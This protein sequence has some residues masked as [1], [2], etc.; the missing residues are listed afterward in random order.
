MDW[1]WT[2]FL[3]WLIKLLLIICYFTGKG[4]ELCYNDRLSKDI[5]FL[6]KFPTFGWWYTSLWYTWLEWIFELVYTDCLFL[7]KLILGINIVL[8]LF[9]YLFWL[10]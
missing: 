5:F 6:W 1:F 4:E 2:F 8:W 7:V 3:G 9:E 10:N